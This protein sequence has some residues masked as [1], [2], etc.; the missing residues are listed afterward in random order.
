MHGGQPL[1]NYFE[2]SVSQ[3]FLFEILKSPLI[4]YMSTGNRVSVLHSDLDWG[5]VPFRSIVAGSLSI[6]AL[7]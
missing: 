3:Q 7:E 1:K 6:V 2:V 5:Y 4:D